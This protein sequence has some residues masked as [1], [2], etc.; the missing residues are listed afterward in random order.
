MLGIIHIVGFATFSLTEST[1]FINGNFITIF[2]VFLATFFAWH[3]Q[4]S[5]ELGS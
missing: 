5:T 4:R 2:L 1:P 3:V